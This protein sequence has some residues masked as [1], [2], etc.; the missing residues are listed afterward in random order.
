MLRLIALLAALPPASS[1]PPPEAGPQATPDALL[2]A[3]HDAPSEDDARGLEERVQQAWLARASASAKLLIARGQRDLEGK[4]ND[5]AVEDFDG[6][7][8][9]DPDLAAGWRL[10]AVARY[11]VGETAGAI[12]DIGEALKREPRDFAALS[13]LSRIAE[14]RGD[15][16][17]AYESWTR[18]LEIDPKTPDGAQRLRDLR[19]HA[20]GEDA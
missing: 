1:A 5:E 15:W 8:A 10:R 6:V 13:T 14:E 12:A 4:A 9:L 18:L 19:R 3:L 20:L 17:G 16:K 11:Q 7:V 2:S